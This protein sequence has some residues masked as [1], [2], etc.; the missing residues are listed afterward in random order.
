[1]GK[2]NYQGSAEEACYPSL[3]VCVALMGQVA[4]TGLCVPP[5]ETCNPCYSPFRMHAPQQPYFRNEQPSSGA[6]QS[7]C[8]CQPSREVSESASCQHLETLL[9]V[10]FKQCGLIA[11]AVKFRCRPSC[12]VK[13]SQLGAGDLSFWAYLAGSHALA[14][15]ATSQ[16]TYCTPSHGH[17]APAHAL[18]WNLPPTPSLGCSSNTSLR[19]Q[20][21]QPEDQTVHSLLLIPWST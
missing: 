13:R 2:L 6:R 3:S 5:T 7:A 8:S 10:G 19:C 17:L 4:L 11:G 18:L 16:T 9:E 14:R 15:L 12:W 21:S 20:G 1:M